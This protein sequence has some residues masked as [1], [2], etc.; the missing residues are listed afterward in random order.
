[1]PRVIIK[2]YNV[3]I[4]GKKFYGPVIDSDTKRYKEIR[5]LTTG[6]G[7]DYTTGCLLDYEYI[8]NHYELRAIDLSRQ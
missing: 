6:K 1:M 7:K 8:K 4:N 3:I 5:E 2:N